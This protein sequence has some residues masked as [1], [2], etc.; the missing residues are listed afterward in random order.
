MGSVLFIEH[1]TLDGHS[2][3]EIRLNAERSLNALSLDMIEAILT[4]LKAWEDDPSLV[5]VMLCGAGE[6]A[7]CAGGDVVALYHSITADVP[8]DAPAEAPAFAERYFAREYRLDYRL[9]TYEKPVI[10]WGSG[11]VMGGGMGLLN[12]ASHRVVTETSRLAMPEVTIGLYPDVGASWFLNRLAGETGRFL[13]LTGSPLNARDAKQ[14]GLADRMLESGQRATL[15]QRLTGAS[16]RS[17]AAPLDAHGVVNRA[18]RDLECEAQEAFDTMPMPAAEHA[19]LMRDLMDHDTV[20][21]QVAAILALETDDP[22]LGRAR[23]TLAHGSAVS[24]KVIDAQL[25]RTRHMSL[26]QVFRSELALSVQ[27]CR[28]GDL[29]EG[30]RALLVDKD[31][32][33]QFRYACL[34]D[35]DPHFIEGMLAEP[36]AQ[37]PLAALGEALD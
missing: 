29:A 33:P 13:A 30:V 27:C 21:Q 35:V 18:L 2:V 31:R 22:W 7:F 28:Q 19:E 15:I 8:S 25:T 34:T 24:V 16:W 20:E 36:W 17:A 14:L 3:G 4:R 32:T 5:A 11:I 6:K 26:A 9:H 12:A 37:N 10:G 1:P 23:Q